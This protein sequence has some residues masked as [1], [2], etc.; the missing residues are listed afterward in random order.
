MS[1][2]WRTRLQLI[3]GLALIVLAAWIVWS[4][5]GGTSDA[6]RPSEGGG[7][8]PSSSST[9]SG[10]GGAATGRRT[11]TESELPPEGRETLAL[12]RTGGPFPYDRDGAT[13]FNRER[14]LPDQPRGYY[15]EYTV[16][17][18]GEDDRGA[19]R[20]VVGE[21]GEVYYTDDHY[22]SFAAVQEER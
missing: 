14:L 3:A 8:P 21:A 10:E 11:I 16:P 15:A 20:L 6:G 4:G 1:R 9:T 7:V 5:T 18:P 12:I 13:F 22:S 19:R 2:T 17:T